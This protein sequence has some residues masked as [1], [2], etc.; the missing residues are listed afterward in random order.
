MAYSSKTPAP[1]TA[2][3]SGTKYFVVVSGAG[4]VHVSDAFLVLISKEPSPVSG[5]RLGGWLCKHHGPSQFIL[6]SEKGG[7]F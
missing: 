4:I 7:M 3:G 5:L 2:T 6:L 1:A